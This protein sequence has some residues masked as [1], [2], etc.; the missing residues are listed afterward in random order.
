MK[1]L[2]RILVLAILITCLGVAGNASAYTLSL[3]PDATT[4]NQ[5]SNLSIGVFI[6]LQPSE[7]LIASF[8]DVSFD[9]YVLTYTGATLGSEFPP[10]WVGDWNITSYLSPN[11]PITFTLLGDGGVTSLKNPSTSTQSLSILLAT[12]DFHIADST[13][14]ST[15]LEFE[16]DSTQGSFGPFYAPLNLEE[17]FGTTVNIV[18]TNPVPEPSTMLLFGVGV[19]GLFGW[20]RKT[21]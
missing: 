17:T 21:H 13:T 15:S 2:P 6:A 1:N 7:E 9:S 11:P 16:V 12:L 4:K 20:M 10:E 3:V 8:F 14:S 18:G 5:G 19:A